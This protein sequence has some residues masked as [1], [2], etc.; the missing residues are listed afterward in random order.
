MCCRKRLLAC[1]AGAGLAVALAGC[2]GALDVTNLFN[3]QLL[4]SL[5]LNGTV[6]TLPGQAPGLLVTVDN[7]TSLWAGLTV[8]YL[9]PNGNSQTYTTTLAPGDT[10]GRMLVCPV[11]QITLGDLSN[12]QQSGAVVYLGSGGNLTSAPTIDVEAY[13]TA[14]RAGVN[15]D[16]GDEII[17][18]V[19][20]SSATQSGYQTY[21]FFRRAGSQ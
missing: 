17:F 20:P 5:G 1:L 4:S 7:R 15:Y 13:G 19:V 6:A 18:A 12:L 8:A 9:D 10:S 3:P 21:A 16:C 2:G 14:L 11:Q